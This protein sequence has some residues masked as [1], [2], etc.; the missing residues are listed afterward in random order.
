MKVV[1]SDPFEVFY[2]DNIALGV[3]FVPKDSSFYC[4][5][6]FSQMQIWKIVNL[7]LFAYLKC[8]S[9]NW[10][11]VSIFICFLDL[12]HWLVPCKVMAVKT[13]RYTWIWPYMCSKILYKSCHLLFILGHYKQNLNSLTH[14]GSSFFC[15]L[16]Q[17][18]LTNWYVIFRPNTSL[19]VSSK[20]TVFH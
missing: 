13:G 1:V 17:P 11:K 19:L 9:L 18:G 12:A 16:G 2:C 14:K 8:G 7:L 20:G 3:L 5:L 15:Y 6:P 4:L 10:A